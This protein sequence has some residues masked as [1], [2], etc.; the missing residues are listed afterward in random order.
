MI[1]FFFFAESPIICFS[2]RSPE[3]LEGASPPAE[4]EQSMQGQGTEEGLEREKPGQVGEGTAEIRVLEH[5]LGEEG[6]QVRS[7]SRRDH[8]LQRPR[9]QWE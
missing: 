5:G 3:Q 4:K 2:F 1:V 8:V 7:S 9:A 6:L